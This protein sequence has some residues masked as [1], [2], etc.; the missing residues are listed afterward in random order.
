M[1][2]GGWRLSLNRAMEGVRAEPGSLNEQRGFVNTSLGTKNIV[3]ATIGSLGDLYPCLALGR[4]L[5]IRDCRVTVA[6]TP[7]YSNKVEGCGLSF[8]P[9]RADWDLT[10]VRLIRSCEDA[11]R[12]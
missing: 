10:D 8:R 11:K 3:I 9:I 5:L 2:G 12:C 1:C 6:T 4:G 7:Y